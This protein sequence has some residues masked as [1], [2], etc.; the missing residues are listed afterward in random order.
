MLLQEKNIPLWV[1]FLLIW[2]YY[3]EGF[4]HRVFNNETS[5]KYT[6]DRCVSNVHNNANELVMSS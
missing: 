3:N 5:R 1:K 6:A 2:T 4:Q